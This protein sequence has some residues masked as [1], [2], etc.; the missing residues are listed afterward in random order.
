MQAPTKFQTA[1]NLK[2]AKALGLTVPSNLLVAADEG[3]SVEI[4]GPVGQR[5]AFNRPGAMAGSRTGPGRQGGTPA[6][7]AAQ[8]S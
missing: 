6:R 1:V 7:A 4:L 2:T 5:P 8:P 3:G